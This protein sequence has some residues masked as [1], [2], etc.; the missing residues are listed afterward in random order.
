MKKL[1]ED[2]DRK[3]E[4]QAASN[5]AH[6][7]IIEE[8]GACIAADQGVLYSGEVSSCNRS[9]ISRVHR[10]LLHHLMMF[11]CLLLLGHEAYDSFVY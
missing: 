3:I 11:S 2:A 4:E 1:P 7:A 6:A 8:Q 10:C 9:K 5:A